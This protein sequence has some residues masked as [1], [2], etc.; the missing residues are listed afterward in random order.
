MRI[1][2]TGGLGFVGSTIV[3]QYLAAGHEVIVVDTIHNAYGE[4]LIRQNKHVKCYQA[5]IVNQ[6]H[7][8]RIF[9]DVRPDIVNHQ[10]AQSSVVVSAN[11]PLL[12]A[13]V[14]IEGLLTILMNCTSA[15]VQK[16]I[17]ASSGTVYGTPERIPV[18]ETFPLHPRS[19]YGITKAAGEWYIRYWQQT[20]GLSYTILRNSNIYG[21]RQKASGTSGVIATFAR[22]F[23]EHQPITIHGSGEQQKDF[24]YVNDVAHANLLALERGTNNVFCIATGAGTSINR[25]YQLLSEVVG[26]Q[27]EIIR[28]P[29]HGEDIP[30]ACFSPKKAEHLLQWK[31]LVSLEEGIRTTIY[32]FRRELCAA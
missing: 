21:P 26:Y 14:N 12:D 22:R 13:Q 1:L 19:P 31:P 24:V 18:D 8:R 3:D 11:N 17:F 20:Y 29:G 25:I 30:C 23:L 5:S 10:A 7:I 27:V 4:Q 9:K 28:T 15:G 32:F 2:V 6:D 16:I